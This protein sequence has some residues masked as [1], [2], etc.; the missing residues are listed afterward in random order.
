MNVSSP[1]TRTVTTLAGLSALLPCHAE[2]GVA[3]NPDSLSHAL[4]SMALFGLSG[5]LIAII[6]YKLFDL[7]TPGNLHREI[8]ENRNVAAAVV[9][10]AVII[11][12]SL[13][14]ASAI[15]G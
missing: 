14:V 5:V 10:A 13:I 1:L 12:V 9:A 4:A 7:A 2:G 8:I 3:W 11:G 15:I 6:G